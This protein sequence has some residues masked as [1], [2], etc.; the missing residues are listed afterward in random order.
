[1]PNKQF[2]IPTESGP[3]GGGAGSGTVTSV[4]M[5]GDGTVLNSTVTGSPVTTSGTLAPSLK[6]QT[7]NTVLAGPTSG[8]AV[9]PTF[10]SLVSGDLPAGTGTVTSV[11]FTGDGTVLS[12]T[13]SE[14]VTTSGTVTASLA[15]AGA[16]T[17]LG[18]ATGSTAAPSYGQIVNAQITNSTIDLTAKVTG[19]LPAANG[20]VAVS[21]AAGLGGMFVGFD[22]IWGVYNNSVGVCTAANIVDAF[23]FVQKYTQTFTRM[24]IR[25]TTTFGA[26]SHIGVALYDSSGNRITNATTGALDGTLVSGATQVVTVSAVTL[27]PGIYYVGISTDG[28]GA[29]TGRVYGALF[30]VANSA[31]T[32]FTNTARGNRFVTGA[33]ASSGGVPPATLGA[34]SSNTTTLGVPLLWVE[35]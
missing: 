18:N 3:G 19:V 15:T 8:G 14:A 7:A 21:N 28:S 26:S 27:N 6:T 30:A 29:T 24:A 23:Q 2:L 17:V 13:P 11:T 33:S 35:P 25:V 1:M 16:N 12:S 22:G 34:L 9:A 20:G 31:V 10:R 5:T 32:Q 4:A